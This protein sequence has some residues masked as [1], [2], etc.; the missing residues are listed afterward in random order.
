MTK[1]IPRL[2]LGCL[3]LAVSAMAAPNF[4]GDWKLNLSKSEYGQVPAPESVVR[5]IKHQDPVLEISTHQKGQA[6]D[7]MNSLK[8]TT[9]GKEC[10]NTTQTGEVKGT[11]KWDGN[12]L[13]ISSTRKIQTFDIT[14]KETWSLSDDGKTLTILNHISLPQQGDFDVKQVFEKQ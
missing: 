14:S 10:T 6:G 8:Y 7:V 13:V 11:A 4:S 5:S 1:I 2:L 12:K 3:I 9:D